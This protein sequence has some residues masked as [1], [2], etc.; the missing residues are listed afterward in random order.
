MQKWKFGSTRIETKKG[1]RKK[2]K[3]NERGRTKSGCA[4]ENVANNRQT[5]QIEPSLLA[6]ASH[7]IVFSRAQTPYSPRSL[8]SRTS[9]KSLF[10]MTDAQTSENLNPK[11]KGDSCTQ[12]RLNYL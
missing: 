8:S 2:E 6:K 11:R 3:E 5:I 7:T 4:D 9:L 12:S 10:A 1:K